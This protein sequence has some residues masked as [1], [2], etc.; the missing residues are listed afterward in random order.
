MND[1]DMEDAVESYLAIRAARDKL[2]TDYEAKDADLKKDMSELEKIML[3]VCNQVN[4]DSLKTKHGT[5]MRKVEENYNCKDW[6]SFTKFILEHKAVHLLQ[7]RIHQGSLKEFMS[8]HEGSG[9]PDGVDV[10]REY[11]ISVRKSASK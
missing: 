4:A 5:I 10:F 6:D 3:S 11:A 2:R 8:E 9:L 7:R 1:V